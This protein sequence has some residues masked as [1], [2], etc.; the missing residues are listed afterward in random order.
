MITYK[1]VKDKVV[2]RKEGINF[3]LTAEQINEVLDIF[4]SKDV[5][6]LVRKQGCPDESK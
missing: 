5:I 2:L 1:I 4:M 6:A 3:G